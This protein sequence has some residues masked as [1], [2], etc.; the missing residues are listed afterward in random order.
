MKI[1]FYISDKEIEVISHLKKLQDRRN[2]S[3]YLVNLIKLDMRAS[4]D[5]IL[6]YLVA[7]LSEV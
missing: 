4:K 7:K 1:D 5:D 2:L 3:Q 6:K